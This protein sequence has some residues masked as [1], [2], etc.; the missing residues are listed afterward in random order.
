MKKTIMHN[1][2][3]ILND[4]RQKYVFHRDVLLHYLKYGIGKNIIAPIQNKQKT[5]PRI[6]HYCWFG[7]GKYSEKIKKCIESWHKVLPEYQF[8]L[9]NEDNFPPENGLYPFAEQAMKDKKWAF[10]SDV[11]R[12]HALYTVG[13]VYVDT[14]IEMLKSLNIFL[15]YDFFSSF[16]SKRHLSTSLMAAKKGNPY[17]KYLLMWYEHKNYSSKDYYEI[18]NTKII[19]KLTK[20]TTNIVLNNAEYQFGNNKI[21]PYDYFCPEKMDNNKFKITEHTY[22]IHHVIRSWGEK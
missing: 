3:Y 19:T 22:C 8:M 12:L 1:L 13:G 5:I 15:N 10:V 9:W 11:A 20:L 21:F 16:E 18:A 2:S 6:L 17:I 14:D 4:Y 7:R